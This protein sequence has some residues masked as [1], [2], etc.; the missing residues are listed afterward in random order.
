[1][2]PSSPWSV[3]VI[4][5]A[6]NAEKYIA[7]AIESLIVQTNPN[8][9]A[10]VVDDGSTDRTAAIVEKF[11]D[12]DDRIRLIQQ[13]NQGG[14]AARNAGLAKAQTDWVLFFDADDWLEAQY[15]EQMMAMLQSNPELDAVR[16]GWQRVT[17]D[18]QHVMETPTL[19]SHEN[20]FITCVLTSSFQVD[21][22]VLRRSVAQSVG[23]FD[24]SMKAG[25]D[26]DFWQRV[27][28]TGARFGLVDQVL[29]NHRTVPGSVS[30]K[31][32][33]LLTHSLAIIERG[34]SIDPRVV[35]P[36]P[37]YAQGL[38]RRTLPVVNFYFLLW[39]A[40]LAIAAGEDVIA[41][42]EQ[43][44]EWG[45]PDV[46]ASKI[47]DSLRSVFIASGLPPQRWQE[48]WPQYRESI[49]EF[50]TV[51]AADLGK[52]EL[53]E[54]TLW[55][56]A[57]RLLEKGV[58]QSAYTLKVNDN[59]TIHGCTI[60]ITQPIPQIKADADRCHC[61]LKIGEQ[62][63]G[64]IDLAFQSG[65]ISASVLADKISNDFFWLILQRFF[66]ENSDFDYHPEQHDQI[67]WEHFLQA[68]TNQP[69]WNESMF[70]HVEAEPDPGVATWSLADMPMMVDITQSIPNVRSNSEQTSI[71]ILLTIGGCPVGIVELP[72]HDRQI[73]ASALR[74]GLL[75]AG[76]L[77]LCR[78]TVREAILRKPL[79]N[80]QSLHDR[81]CQNLENGNEPLTQE[82]IAQLPV[83][84]ASEPQGAQS[85]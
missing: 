85:K 28:R 59:Y 49:Q 47:A 61:W 64:T 55:T 67:G 21:T 14:C 74:S 81:L 40:G 45:D 53:V 58:S 56:M 63:L 4:I 35:N 30:S 27:A 8:W 68:I 41:L 17:E 7:V 38:D 33:V 2:I 83:L 43:V 39:C 82:A 84:S 20:M 48:V 66:Q 24:L 23:G 31:A 75:L 11:V 13:A 80:G 76:G 71:K 79:R 51:I 72:L 46:T 10:I 60:D 15:F 50:L 34:H 6:Y 78:L 25:Q 18:G 65:L 54:S 32:A 42:I 19:Y 3:A 57:W 62:S 52:P 1:M 44:P 22:C 36:H 16:C 5:P 29:S 26:W 9:Q 73:T 37:D 77:E 70:Y 69:T 12:R